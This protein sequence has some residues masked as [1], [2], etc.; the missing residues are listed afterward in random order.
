MMRSGISTLSLVV[1]VFSAVFCFS[2]LSRVH[3][4]PRLSVG[5]LD[6]RYRDG[7]Q[8]I[9][10]LYLVFD[11]PTIESFESVQFGIQSDAGLTIFMFFEQPFVDDPE[12]QTFYH[13]IWDEHRILAGTGS[14]GFDGP[15]PFLP[16]VNS[17]I[18]LGTLI[19]DVEK[20][21]NDLVETQ[22]LRLGN[23]HCFDD[24]YDP[25]F[26]TVDGGVT[27]PLD[28]VELDVNIG[29]DTFIRGDANVDGE[30][31]FSDAIQTL[32]WRFLGGVEVGCVDALDFDDSG[33]VEMDD[34][35]ANLE[36]LF[37][38][39]PQ[40][41]APYPDRGPDPTLEDSL[42]CVEFDPDRNTP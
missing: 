9:V 17:R 24:P 18:R 12:L 30:V 38:G 36:F 41:A 29:E 20:Q 21:T 26:V 11:D 1:F 4:S 6:D 37:L 28:V 7:E 23:C 39:G 15:P 32:R 27:L 5:D 13:R 22:A 35:I 40:P 3:A 42:D 10:P 25:A 8:I 16:V 14:R 33:V 19:V 2:F 31:D 34:G